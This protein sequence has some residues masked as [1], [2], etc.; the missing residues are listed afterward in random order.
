VLE[1]N[2]TPGGRCSQI[3]HGGH[4]NL[5]FVGS[6]TDPGTGLPMALLSAGLTT[7][8]IFKEMRAA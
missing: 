4:H 7:E 6:S 3:V 1:K 5:Y 8:P 2:T